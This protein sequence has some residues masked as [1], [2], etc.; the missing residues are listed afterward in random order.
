MQAGFFCVC[1]T[2]KY[3][4]NPI[5]SLVTNQRGFSHARVRALTKPTIYK[6]IFH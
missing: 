1:P 2:M 3:D 6:I 5:S 4:K